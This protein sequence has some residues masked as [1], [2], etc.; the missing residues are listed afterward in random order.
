MAAAVISTARSLPVAPS[1]AAWIN[2]ARE[3]IV[4]GRGLEDD[5]SGSPNVAFEIGKAGAQKAALRWLAHHNLWVENKDFQFGVYGTNVPPVDGYTLY[6]NETP[7]NKVV[8]LVERFTL[9]KKKPANGKR[10]AP[11]P[12]GSYRQPQNPR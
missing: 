5:S 9:A 10:G 11:T 6:L 4:V 8:I 1:I 2:G 3:V 7:D 12:P